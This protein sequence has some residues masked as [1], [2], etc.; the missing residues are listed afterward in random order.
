M[1]HGLLLLDLLGD[2]DGVGDGDGDG[3]VGVDDRE[4]KFLKILPKVKNLSNPKIDLIKKDQTLV[5]VLSL[6]TAVTA[7]YQEVISVSSVFS[8]SVNLNISNFLLFVKTIP[9]MMFP[10]KVSRSMASPLKCLQSAIVM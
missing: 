5:I 1:K 2:G 4:R 9:E 8:H 10:E 6:K 3:D 7:G